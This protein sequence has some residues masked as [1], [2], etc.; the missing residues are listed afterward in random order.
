MGLQGDVRAL[1]KNI[2]RKYA[3]VDVEVYRAM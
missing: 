3:Y 1:L 2:Y